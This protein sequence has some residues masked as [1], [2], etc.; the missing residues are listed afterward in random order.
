M[1]QSREDTGHSALGLVMSQMSDAIVTA[2]VTDLPVRNK[3][4][5]GFSDSY[6]KPFALRPWFLWKL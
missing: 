2:S 3:Q 5:R 1:L 6:R 4:V